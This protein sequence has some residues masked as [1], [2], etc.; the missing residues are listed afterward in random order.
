MLDNSRFS[1]ASVPDRREGK[2]QMH[3]FSHANQEDAF[4]I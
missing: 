2:G 3:L 4:F 1:D